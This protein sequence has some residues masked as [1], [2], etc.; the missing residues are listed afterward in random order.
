[1]KVEQLKEIIEKH[2]FTIREDAD[3]FGAG[4]AGLDICQYTPMGE[5]WYE[6]FEVSDDP[7]TF[8][9][10]LKSRVDGWD[11]EDEAMPYIEMRGER[12]VPS[13]IRDLLDDADWKLEQL[14]TLLADIQVAPDEEDTIVE[15]NKKLQ[16]DEIEPENNNEENEEQNIEDE[17]EQE[18]DEE[19]DEI[20]ELIQDW[21]DRSPLYD[22]VISE[23]VED[24]E[25]YDGETKK[26]RIAK[27]L[28]DV[29]HGLVTGIVSSMIYYTDTVAFYNEYEDDIYDLVEYLVDNGL[30]PLEM[31]KQH[32]EETEIIMQTDSVKNRIAWMAYEEIAYMFGS[33]L[34]VL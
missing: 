8:I 5:D 21:K 17:E 22:R 14:E 11:S 1:M 30:E 18:T 19:I 16:E 31:L 4:E 9:A 24:S 26:D 10:N 34:G 6:T 23:I 29:M 33:E 12:G 20:D 3:M 28:D 7:E 32:H 2:G 13:S 15:E 27:R 25:N